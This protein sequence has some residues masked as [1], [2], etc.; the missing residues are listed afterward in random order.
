MGFEQ[1]RRNVEEKMAEIRRR[2]GTGS[3]ATGAAPNQHVRRPLSAAARRRIAAAQTKRWAALKKAQ[4]KTAAPA[5]V[6]TPKK[7]TMSAA[8]RK[9][10]GEATRKRWAEIRK[11]KAAKE[12]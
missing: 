8:A 12:R 7:R 1:M 5:K 4:G 3:R 2:L 10:I 11:K 6:S 9:R